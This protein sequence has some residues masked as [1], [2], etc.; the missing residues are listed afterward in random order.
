MFATQRNTLNDLQINDVLKKKR[1]YFRG[2]MHF[3]SFK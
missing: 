3:N 1:N 2:V